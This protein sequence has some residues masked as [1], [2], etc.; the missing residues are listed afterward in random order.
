MQ[1]L[2]LNNPRLEFLRPALERWGESIERFNQVLG[3]GEG[4]Y[5]QGVQGNIGTLSAAIWQAELVTLQGY[6]SK[7]QRDEGERGAQ[8]DLLIASRDESAYLHAQ[9]RWPKVGRLDLSGALQEAGAVAKGI[10][11]ASQLKLA[12]LF[13]SPVKLEKHASPEELQDM[14]DDLQKHNACAIAWCFPY[15]YR[16]LHD[17][18]GQYYPGVALLLKQ[19]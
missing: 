1:G 19:V 12:A 2:I 18:F 8:C 6:Q 3:D 9:Q 10:A 17:E 16:K 11:Y 5:W 7:K 13:V 4:P 14:V 15:G